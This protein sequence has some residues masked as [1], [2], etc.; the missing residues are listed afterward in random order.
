MV[1]V[2]AHKFFK[3][4]ATE[5]RHQ[6][7]RIPY[8]QEFKCFSDV[9]CGTRKPP[10]GGLLGEHYSG[11]WCHPVLCLLVHPTV[12]GPMTARPFGTVR[13]SHAWCS[14]PRRPVYVTLIVKSLRPC[15]NM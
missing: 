1:R 9:L 12:S 4:Q 11:G 2:L 10:R 5:G 3:P 14:V 7:N 15:L 13:F 8:A 6:F